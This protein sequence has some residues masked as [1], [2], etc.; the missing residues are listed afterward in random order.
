M[1]LLP[2][3]AHAHV[4]A[5]TGVSPSAARWYLAPELRL[6]T[7]EHSREID[8]SCRMGYVRTGAYPPPPNWTPPRV[9]PYYVSAASTGMGPVCPFALA[10]PDRAAT[11]GL[12]LVFVTLDPLFSAAECQ[13]VIEEAKALTAV[14]GGGSDFTLSDTS[15]NIA[16]AD[17][18]ATRAWLNEV[19]HARLAKLAA[20]CYGEVA[21]GAGSELHLYR[22]LVVQYD[23]AQGLTHQQV[24]RDHAL[25]TCVVTLNERSEYAGGGTYIEDLGLACAPPR[26]HGVMQASALRHAG[27]AIES[28]ERWVMVLFMMS[29]KLRYGENVRVFKSRARQ[30]VLP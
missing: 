11:A 8:E 12:P 19:A 4:L 18:P 23:A 26:G 25:V 16:V 22:A 24:H 29:R 14:G 28:G 17:L 9:Q 13:M 10:A 30:A 20:D 15:R 2:A 27:H 5:S 21:I 3:Q 7:L 1:L 6:N